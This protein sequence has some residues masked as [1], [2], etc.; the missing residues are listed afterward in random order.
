MGFSNPDNPFLELLIWDSG[1]GIPL[2]LQE[3]IFE[4]F[5]QT[6]ESDKQHGFGLGLFIT[7]S[8]IDLLGGSITL[9]SKIDKGSSFKCNIPLKTSTVKS[10][11]KLSETLHFDTEIT[12]VLV[13]DEKAQLVFL[14]AILEQQN[15]PY[16]SFQN[17]KKALQFIKTH[18]PDI[19]LTDIQ[20]PVMDGFSLTKKIKQ[21]ITTAHIPVIGLTG[22]NSFSDQEF[23]NIGFSENLLKPYKP[24]F[25]L[26][27]IS[28]LLDLEITTNQTPNKIS[29]SSHKS[30]FYDLTDIIAFMDNDLDA[31]KRVLSTFYK[32][33]L[34]HIEKWEEAIVHKNRIQL[35]DLAHKMYPMFM[36]INAFKI[37]KQLRKID[38]EDINLQNN[39]YTECTL[40]K[41][42]I[43][44]T[45]RDL[46]GFIN[47]D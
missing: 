16:V 44:K 43:E 41:T 11:P 34:N 42:E 5:S 33:T 29:H 38:I 32:S 39:L 14:E 2:Q 3:T 26:S 27:K 40:L 9:E 21:D 19:V 36:Q 37:S 15:I 17:S 8:L 45:I 35:K 22:N 47:I 1:S 20:M 10:L 18:K 30:A 25:L 12:A 24:N 28:Q 31:V 46:R 13:D 6:K 23:K 7:K 4:A